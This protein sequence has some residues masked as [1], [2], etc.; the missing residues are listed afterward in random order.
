LRL[1]VAG[2]GHVEEA[3]REG[4]LGIGSGGHHREVFG[5]VELAVDGEAEE[6]E[7][8][9]VVLDHHR[10]GRCYRGAGIARDDEID[11]VDIEEL[12]IEARH[13][14]RI[15]LVVVPDEL[16]WPAEEAAFG[17]DVFLPD[18]HGQQRRL[19]DGGEPAGERHA[20]ADGD[21]LV[22]A[23]GGERGQGHC[24]HRG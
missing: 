19:A 20:K 14:R 8:Q 12:R 21:R 4:A 10:H 2:H 7:E 6:P 15:A 24:E 1:G 23:G 13:R 17:V 3:L 18:L 9:S 11:L 22:G 16:H 5:I